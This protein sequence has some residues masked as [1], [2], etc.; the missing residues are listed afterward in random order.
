MELKKTEIEQMLWYIQCVEE[1]GG[2][3]YG[4]RDYFIKR[5]KNII[6]YLNELLKEQK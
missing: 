2:T 5:E 3:Y 6:E 4:N 1:D